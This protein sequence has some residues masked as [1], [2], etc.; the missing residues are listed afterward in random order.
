MDDEDD[1]ISRTKRKNAATALQVVGKEL[2]ALSV[3]QIRRL[4]LPENLREAVLECKKFNKH[5][6]IRRQ[7]QYI[8]KMMRD[9][10]S[11][12]ILA[13]LMQIKAPSS[14]DNALFHL[15]EKWRLQLLED[16]D[17]AARFASDYPDANLGRLRALIGAAQSEREAKRAPKHFREL[18]HFVNALVQERGREP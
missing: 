11:A 6:A 5:E 8:G 2:V 13:Q 16:P 7:M 9:I 14:R 3:E 12:P 18:F 1:F 15:A 10:D 17:A 4:E